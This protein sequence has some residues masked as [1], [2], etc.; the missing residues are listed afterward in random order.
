[1]RV[2]VTL[3]CAALAASTASCSV[4][5]LAVSAL[6]D[7]MAGSGSGMASD[8]DPELIRDAAPFGLKTMEALLESSP[9]NAGLL[10]AL[11]SGFT[12]YANAFVETEALDLRWADP[13]AHARELERARRMY[14]RARDYGLRGLELSRPGVLRLL[15]TSPDSAVVAFGRSSVPLL[16][17]TGAAWGAAIAV[18]LDDPDLVADFPAVRAL[19]GRALSLDPGYENGALHEAMLSVESVPDLMGGSEERARQHFER[20]VELSGG[21]KASPYVSL[22]GGL[23][24]GRQDRREFE[25]LLET[26]LAIDPDAVPS[27]R[28]ANLI[29]QRRARILLSHADYLFVGEEFDP[30]EPVQ[31]DTVPPEV[32]EVR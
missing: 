12:Q 6:A 4:R 19:I 27:I 8:D 26:A 25:A 30:V 13:D 28:L 17:W 14:I 10:L 21:A 7:A 23:S 31:P 2:P 1:M 20:A 18:G 24:V 5:S 29:A 22:A 11:A 32:Q 9:R 16:Y 15:R 3:L